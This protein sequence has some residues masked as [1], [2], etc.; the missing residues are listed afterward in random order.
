M[1]YFPIQI[2]CT[3]TKIAVIGGSEDTVAKIRLLL[4]TDAMITV[5]ADAADPAIVEWHQTGKLQ[6]VPRMM[7]P[8]DL[9]NIRLAYIGDVGPHLRDKAL[10]MLDKRNIPYCVIDDL[11]RSRFITPAIVDRDPVTIAIGTEGTAPVL[12]RKIKAMIEEN[13][14]PHTGILATLSGRFRHYLSHY[15][16]AFRRQFWGRIFDDVAPSIINA[17]GENIA[18]RLD[19][20]MHE[21]LQ[22][23]VTNMNSATAHPS[24]SH[25]PIAFVSAGPGDPDLMTVKARS[26]LD[27]AEVI[28][29]DRLISPAIL[30]LARREAVM[31]DV[32]KTGYGAGM[33]QDMINSLLIT[34]GKT[35]A[36]IIRLKSGDAG[37]FG[38]L[39]EEISACQSAGLN[40]VVVP[41]ITAASATAASMNVS[42]TRRGRNS[43]WRLLTARDMKGFVDCQWQD[44][45]SSGA[46]TAIYMGLKAIPFLQGRL[47]MHGGDPE[48]PVTLASKVSQP[49]QRIIATTLGQ[50]TEVTTY[51]NGPVIIMLGLHPNYANTDH[52]NQVIN[53]TFPDDL[54]IV[55]QLNKDR[56][57]A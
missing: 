17:G 57:S 44:I 28:L 52:I 16:S 49:Q 35:G 14:S 23:T 34:H 29:H 46:I 15:S 13:L 51:L 33:S 43:E 24:K 26:Y 10:H 21:L 27:K 20:A 7:T 40:Y 56:I 9:K 2:R 6:Y 42:L 30:E 3:D 31:I 19:G 55:Q 45:A 22:Q 25:P 36:Q 41:G 39:D 32:G 12:A 8:P 5:Y 38:R 18:E 50:M 4:K 37:V 1:H 53:D 48:L 11:V 47:L 54:N